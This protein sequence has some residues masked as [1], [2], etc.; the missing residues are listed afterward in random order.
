MALGVILLLSSSAYSADLPGLKHVS[1]CAVGRRNFINRA[2]GG[3]D[4][5]RGRAVRVEKVMSKR[6]ATRAPLELSVEIAHLCRLRFAVSETRFVHLGLFLASK[7]QKREKR[8][9]DRHSKKQT[10]TCV[11]CRRSRKRE[12]QAHQRRDPGTNRKFS[13]AAAKKSTVRCCCQGAGKR[14]KHRKGIPR[15][16][17]L[18]LLLLLYRPYELKIVSSGSPSP[19]RFGFYAP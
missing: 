12:K 1:R 11:A 10:T 18:V 15:Q 6:Y 4:H 9:E 19:T 7:Q 14:R 3:E 8:T 13:A 16:V 2:H 5:N 17:R